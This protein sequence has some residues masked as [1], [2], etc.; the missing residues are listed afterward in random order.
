MQRSIGRDRK[1]LSIV[2]GTRGPARHRR[3]DDEPDGMAELLRLNGTGLSVARAVAVLGPAA[4][5]ARVSALLGTDT[6]ETHRVITELE[7]TA[8]FEGQRCIDPAVGARLLRD[9]SVGE[10]R[11]LHGRA[12]EVLHG[13][14]FRPAVVAPHLYAAG[15]TGTAWA[16]RVLVAAAAEA[17]AED[18]LDWAAKYLELGYRA[19]DRARERAAIATRLVAV[20]WRINPSGRTR[21][22][23]RLRA[24]LAAGLVPYPEVPAAVSFMLWHGCGQH[25][26]RALARL[27]RGVGGALTVGPGI[28][29]LCAWVRYTHP[30][31]VERHPD[32]F[33]GRPR[34]TAAPGERDSPHRQAAD[35]LAALATPRPPADLAA[36]A[37]RILAGHRLTITTVEALVA[38]VDCL[39]H[40]DRLDLA[41]AWCTSLLAEAAARHA[42]TWRSVFAA[43]RAETLLRKGRLREAAE[44]A[45]LALNLVPAENLGVWAGRPIGVLVRALTA[46]GKHSEAAAQLRRPVPRAMF[47]SRFALT[48]LS[49]H[50]E[51]CLATGRPEEA[52]RHFRQCGNLMRQWGMDYAW[53]TPWRNDVAAA[54]LAVGRQREARAFASMHLDLVGG[55]D[56][57]RSAGVSLRIL[58]ATADPHRRVSLL[59][60]AVAVARAGDGDLEL[61]MALGDLGRA[62]RSMGDTDRARPLLRDAIRLAEQCDAELLL[63]RLRGDRQPPATEP[64]PRV[65]LAPSAFETLSPAERRVAELAALGKRN[66]DIAAALTITTS[67]V[68]QHLTRVYRKLSVAR[69]SELRFVLAAHVDSTRSAVG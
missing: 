60:R 66:R 55:P 19:S 43:V 31:H 38:A 45:V 4:T 28:E 49:A 22:F 62:Y 5:V 37:Q 44:H 8:A 69:R 6:S 3:P 35:L 13:S 68:E 42:P 40:T 36:A 54:H 50:G 61:A 39:M 2:G 20:E 18:Q 47:E 30:T 11:D 67:T 56:G 41:D 64:I 51:H 57:H 9:L 32:L 21:N 27:E 65:R 23:G 59:R 29:F 24:A 46:Q 1:P 16:A 10:R 26:D 63:R 7:M 33:S 25:V 34:D 15:E 17:V 48:Y 12:A 52:L 53:L 58:A 14:G